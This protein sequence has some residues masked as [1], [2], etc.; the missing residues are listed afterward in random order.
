MNRT[1]EITVG[2]D[3]AHTHV[4]FRC[5]GLGASYEPGTALTISA[6]ILDAAH[7]PDENGNCDIRLPHLPGLRMSAGNAVT[8][9]A[10]IAASADQ[11]LTEADLVF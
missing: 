10:A 2:I 8:I 6:G 5:D 9:G 3:E 7:S 11:L 1:A 4:I